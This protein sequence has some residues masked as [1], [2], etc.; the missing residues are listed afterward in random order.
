MKCVWSGAGENP[1]ADVRELITDS[2]EAN[3]DEDPFS[4]LKE[5][6]TDLITDLI[7]KLRSEASSEANHKFYRDDELANGSEKEADL[8]NQVATHSSK[9]E[10]AVS[11]SSVLDGEVAELHVDLGAQAAQ[12]LK[13]DAMGVAEQIFV[14]TKEDL[15]QD[16]AGIQQA[17]W[18]HPQDLDL[19]DN[20]IIENT[21]EEVQ[22]Q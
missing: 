21:Q 10:A 7:N 18:T 1:F 8:Q 20:P 12:P 3:A 11:K 19:D 16:I 5:L 17:R 13:M 6:I 22:Q 14:T 9:L 15:E 4:T 2:S